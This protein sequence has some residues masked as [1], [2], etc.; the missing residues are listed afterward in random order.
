MCQSQSERFWYSPE[1]NESLHWVKMGNVMS[2]RVILLCWLAAALGHVFLIEQPGSAKF[3][4]MPRW[5]DFCSR[6]C[7]ALLVALVVSALPCIAL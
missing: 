7:V 2:A 5:K 3:G 1:G 4:D 6:I